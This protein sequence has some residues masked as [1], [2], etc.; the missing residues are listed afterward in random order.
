VTALVDSVVWRIPGEVFM[1]AV[2]A[3]PAPSPGLL[4]GVT[5]RLARTPQSD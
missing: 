4:G 5:M 3:S 1:D 2:T